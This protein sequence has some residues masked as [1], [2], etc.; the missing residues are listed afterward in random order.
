MHG[1]PA[2]DE[3]VPGTGFIRALSGS[4]VER[5]IAALTGAGIS[6]ESGIPTFRGAEGYWTVGSRN[7]RP[8]ELATRRAFEAMPRQIWGWY[9]SRLVACGGAQPNAGHLALAR[10]ARA[11]GPERFALIT[12]NVDGLHT[13]S[14]IEAECLYEIHG[15]IQRMRCFA[16]CEGSLRSLPEGLDIGPDLAVSDRLWARLRCDQCG[17]PMR[18]HVLW[19]DEYYEE[20]Y[21]RSESALKALERSDLLLVV[22]TSGATTLPAMAVDYA[23]HSGMEI[24]EINTDRSAFTPAI[25]ANARGE[26]I[27]KPAAAALPGLVKRLLDEAGS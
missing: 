1:P 25:K 14:G 7:Y 17:E 8:Q 12:Q 19:F 11:L 3:R 2:G 13:R 23:V 15:N 5:A 6:A 4:A 26:F 16:E 9:L 24:I 18:P 27:Q 10:L 21:Y 20:K 22:G